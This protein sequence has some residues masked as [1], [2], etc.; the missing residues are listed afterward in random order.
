MTNLQR[1]GQPMMADWPLMSMEPARDGRRTVCIACG[2]SYE[3]SQPS[4]SR[5]C[6]DCQRNPWRAE[7]T[8]EELAELGYG[9][10]EAWGTVA[11]RLASLLIQ[12]AASCRDA[13]CP[14]R[15]RQSKRSIRRH[16]RRVVHNSLRA[17]GTRAPVDRGRAGSMERLAPE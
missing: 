3:P 5:T 7:K 17:L 9:A 6:T 13:E 12:H 2:A 11:Q 16:G 8:V 1:K 14:T 15:L 10:D 4:T